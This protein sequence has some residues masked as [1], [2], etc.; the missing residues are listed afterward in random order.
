[1]KKLTAVVV[2]AAAVA[3]GIWY[4]EQPSDGVEPI[5]WNEATCAHCNMHIGD[6]RYAAQLQ[7]DGGE[8]YNF[9]DP[10]CVF[11]WIETHSPS[12]RQVYFHHHRRQRWLG[13]HEVGFVRVE[14]PTPMGYGLGAVDAGAAPESMSFSEASSAVITGEIDPKK[15]GGGTAGSRTR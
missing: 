8:V 11:E 12:I 6:R 2:I 13:Y 15:R 7:T 1:M 10:G 9:D 3:A 4:L 5:A 14:E